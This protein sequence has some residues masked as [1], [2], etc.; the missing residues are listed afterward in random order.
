MDTLAAAHEL[1]V[2]RLSAERSGPREDPA[3]PSTVQAMQLVINLPKQDPPTRSAVLGDAAVGVVTLCLDPRAGEE[4]FWRDALERWYSHRIRKVARRGRNKAWADVQSLPGVTVGS[5]RAFVPSAVGEVPKELRKLQV[6]GTELEPSGP[7]R[8]SA[9][10][11]TLYMNADLHMSAGKAAAQAGH[12]SMLMAAAL[13]LERVRDWQG[14]GY[15]V[16]VVEAPAAELERRSEQAGAV[17]VRDAGFTE[18]APGSV[19]A[20]AVPGAS[21]EPRGAA[22][23]RG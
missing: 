8:V 2:T 10:L 6:K 19:T 1:L 4:G 21:A 11:P 13:P 14:S 12:A 5:V 18:V 9:A 15:G 20:V 7:L 22:A 17:V 16:N 3:D 23:P